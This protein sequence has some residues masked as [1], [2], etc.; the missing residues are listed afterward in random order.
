MPK[1]LINRVDQQVTAS[2]RAFMQNGLEAHPLAC[3]SVVPLDLDTQGYQWIADLDQFA[4][5]LLT[6]PTAAEH[7]DRVVSN[8][9]VQWPIGVQLW[10]V[11]AGTAAAYRGDGP[12]PRYV[13]D[14]VGAEAAMA[15]I[16]ACRQPHDRI[17]VVTGAEGGQAVLGRPGA[18]RLVLFRRETR[19][20]NWPEPS[21]WVADD[22]ILHGSERLL[23][24]C[25]ACFDG[26]I[27]V[28]WQ[29]HHLV[30]TARAIPHLPAGTRYYLIDAPTPE[31]V[32]AVLAEGKD[33]VRI[34]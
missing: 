32:L 10:A 21:A 14:A 1:L 31:A 16:E 29:M 24:A 13:P 7:F 27:P 2:V 12:Q 3:E 5:V 6:S 19:C 34:A 8:R 25:K 30:T 26:V 22:L 23:L 17:L 9:W 18:D 11:G 15:A 28:L 33:D 4:H 20:P